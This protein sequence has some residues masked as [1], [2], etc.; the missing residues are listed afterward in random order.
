MDGCFW[1]STCSAKRSHTNCEHGLTKIGDWKVKEGQ[2]I[3]REYD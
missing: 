2:S 3:L 1:T